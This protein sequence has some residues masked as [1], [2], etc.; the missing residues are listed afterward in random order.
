MRNL[1]VLT[2]YG[3]AL[4]LTLIAAI[5][6]APAL[7]HRLGT[8]RGVAALL[9]FGFG[10]VLT[11]TLLPDGDA[12]RG[13]GSD[14]VCD[15]SRIGLIPLGRLTR[16]NEESL[17]VLLLVP[18]G[19]A[20]AFLPRSRATVLIAIAAVS[21]PFVVEAVQLLVPA[22]GRGCQT[23]DLFD[24]LLGLAIGAVVG[25]LLRPLLR[26]PGTVRDA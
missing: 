8:R 5:G 20:V 15:T 22:L 23:A 26:D 1:L 11:A 25:L 4:L 7:A 19:I 9:V 17:N 21:L 14:G 3:S 12:L 16:P 13:F 18:L 6:L 2:I 24:N 10:L